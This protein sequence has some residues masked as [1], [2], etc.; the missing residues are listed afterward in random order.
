MKMSLEEKSK[1]VVKRAQRVLEIAK[2]MAERCG[3]QVRNAIEDIRWAPGY[4]EPGYSS[5][6]GMILLANWNTVDEYNRQTQS[7]EIVPGGDLPKRLCDI[8]EYIGVDIEWSDEWTECSECNRTFRTSPD[9][10]DWKMASA[11]VGEEMLC[12][13]CIKKEYPSQYLEGLINDPTNADT[14]DIDLSEHGWTKVNDDSYQN[15]WHPGQTDSSKAI[16]AQLKDHNDVIFQVDRTG[17][18]DVRFSAWVRPSE[19]SIRGVVQSTYNNT[20]NISD[21]NLFDI[22]MEQYK[23]S[24]ESERDRIKEIVN[25]EIDCPRKAR[26]SYEESEE[27]YD[28]SSRRDSDRE[29]FH[30]DC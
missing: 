12:H 29:N 20:P 22:V 30:S 28:A 10:F 2:R 13:E 6:H 27:Y 11:V 17:Q 23:T 14:L 15:G 8:L 7:R 26:Q 18:F 4:A 5:K 1:N 25:N 21:D 9:G 3:W 24:C 16:F 19:D